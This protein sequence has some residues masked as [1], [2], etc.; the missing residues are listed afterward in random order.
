[1]TP[2]PLNLAGRANKRTSYLEILP[3]N[4]AGWNW[5]YAK[6]RPIRNNSLKMAPFK[7]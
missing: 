7:Q 5:A 6:S 2:K 1:M 3:P 4:N